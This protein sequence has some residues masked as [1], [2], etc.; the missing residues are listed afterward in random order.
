MIL[1]FVKANAKL[2]SSVKEC[3][4]QS[5]L[6]VNIFFQFDGIAVVEINL[7]GFQWTGKEQEMD[8][9]LMGRTENMYL[10]GDGLKSHGEWL[11]RL[12]NKHNNTVA[13]SDVHEQ[14]GEFREDMKCR[15]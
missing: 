12:I 3:C 11:F 2:D 4:T 1:C 14:N 7:D 13:S 8:L 15:G 5:A 9:L 10:K 6:S